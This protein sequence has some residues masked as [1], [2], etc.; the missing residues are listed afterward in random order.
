MSQ[1][2]TRSQAVG[3]GDPGQGRKVVT[4]RLH[5]AASPCSAQVGQVHVLPIGCTVLGRTASADEHTIVFA[6]ALMSRRHVAL[7]HAGGAEA[8]ELQDLESHN[9]TRLGGLAVRKASAGHG[10]VVRAG[11]TVFVVEADLGR[12]SECAEPD[13]DMPGRSEVARIARADLAFAAPDA[14]PALIIGDTGTGK[15]YAAAALHRHSRRQ[16]ALVRVNL[17]ALPESLFESELFG[18]ARGA[19]TGAVAARSGRIR[20]ADGGTLVLDEIGEMPLA[21]QPKLLR[22]LEEGGLRSVGGAADVAIDVRF[23]ASTNADVDAL[24]ATGRFRRDLAARLTGHT[25]RLAPLARRKP[26][27]MALADAVLPL[28]DGTPWG[29]ALAADAA[30]LLLLHD[31]PDNLRGLRAAL[32]RAAANWRAE[33]LSESA[34][35]SALVEGVRARCAGLL[36][37]EG[38]GA[39]RREPTPRPPHR[40]DR[41][42]PEALIELLLRH[43]GSIDGV[44]RE[45]GRHRRQVYRWMGYAGID[46][47]AR[48]RIRDGDL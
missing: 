35:P 9:G 11:G 4:W 30:E 31:W 45:L 14:L 12:N 38:N 2:T 1:D 37:A 18:H 5:I 24:V 13:R 28:H 41:P 34:L 16:G 48:S 27:L 8:L 6:D 43:D 15:E 7:I 42:T 23:C 36:A 26:D 17:A 32:L 22:V 21:L 20:E 46:A 47:T 25:I 19:F 39:A 40:T 44:A 33:P 29:R 10:A 3:T